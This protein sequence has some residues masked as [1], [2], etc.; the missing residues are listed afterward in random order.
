MA[1]ITTNQAHFWGSMGQ[2]GRQRDYP[3]QS[4]KTSMETIRAHARSLSTVNLNEALGCA[5]LLCEFDQSFAACRF[6]EKK[7]RPLLFS[8]LWKTESW[9][10]L[11]NLL[12]FT[13]M[14]PSGHV[15]GG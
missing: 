1:S 10:T 6:L 4:Y 12:S 7:H 13:N 2:Y 9:E 15:G 8:D 5:H 11:A 3:I 14:L